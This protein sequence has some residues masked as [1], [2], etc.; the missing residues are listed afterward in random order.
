MDDGGWWV[1]GGGWRMG[2]GVSW[3]P[4]RRR[5]EGYCVSDLVGGRHKNLANSLE[6]LLLQSRSTVGGAFWAN[7]TVI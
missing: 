7:L 4:V 1:V 3:R 2:V 6:T 5:V